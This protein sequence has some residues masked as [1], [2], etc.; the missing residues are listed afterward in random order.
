VGRLGWLRITPRYEVG[1][2]P[3][4]LVIKHGG[5]EDQLSRKFYGMD[6]FRIE[7][8]RKVLREN[9][10]SERQKNRC[11]EVLEAKTRVY[12]QGCLKRGKEDEADF[13][14]KQLEECRHA[15]L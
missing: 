2:I 10:L 13:Y 4:A 1:L 9:I 5:H 6:R 11:L 15:L 12:A 7:A 14:Y 8:I 3:D